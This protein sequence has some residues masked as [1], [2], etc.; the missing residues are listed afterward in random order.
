MISRRI[1]FTHSEMLVNNTDMAGVDALDTLSTGA[2]AFKEPWRNFSHPSEA[3]DMTTT[4][5]PITQR[6]G[7]AQWNK[8]RFTGHFDS[9]STPI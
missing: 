4:A 2:A 3:S 9:N 1:N 8:A 7:S 6:S 5:T